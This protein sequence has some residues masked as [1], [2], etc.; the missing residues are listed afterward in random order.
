MSKVSR[1]LSLHFSTKYFK[2]ITHE[3]I[4][5]GLLEKVENNDIKAIQ[6]TESDCII[7]LRD[8]Q[9][10]ENLLMSDLTVKNRNITLID[11][12]KQI[13]NVT[14]KDAPV[15][16]DDSFI[17][18]HMMAYG[19]VVS[20][21]IKRGTIKNTSIE[22]GTRYLQI[23]NCVSTLPNRTHFGDHEVRLFADNNR[24]ECPYCKNTDHP[25][26]KCPNKPDQNVVCFKCNKSGHIAFNCQN[27]P[28]C[29]CCKQEGHSKDDCQKLA[30]KL[31]LKYGKCASEILES[32]EAMHDD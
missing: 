25:S 8:S 13:T 6:I 16:L 1:H 30:E 11:V 26:F 27:D 15:E 3:D 12:E 20:G 24:T 5:N 17:V 23:L 7:T 29:Q 14:I 28:V 9:V 18:K 4:L 32:N 2:G 22:T 10:K 31:A 21:L 19:Q